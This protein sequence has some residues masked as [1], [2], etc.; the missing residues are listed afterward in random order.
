MLSKNQIKFIRSLQQKKQRML[1]KQFVIEGSRMVLELIDSHRSFLTYVVVTS[2]FIEKHSLSQHVP[3]V[4]T[5]EETFS[6]LTT[7]IQ[8][9]GILAVFRQ[10]ELTYKASN[11][12]LFLD[13]IQDPG[14]MGTIIRLADWF[15]I[16]QIV[17]SPD[18]VD[19]F[20][21]K[22]VQSSMGSIFRVPM[23]YAQLEELL[24]STK[25][26]VYGAMLDGDSIYEQQLSATGIIVMGNEGN[27]IRPTVEHY[28]SNKILI[29]R[30]GG[31]ES[32]N[33]STATGILLS[34]F[35]RNG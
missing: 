4:V 34:E 21:P 28:L 14:N 27:G 6:K 2:S 20:N 29:P 24:A 5:D 22:V 25:L 26:P 10:P 35:R 33:V 12:M 15:G 18:C 23:V 31:G 9:Q 30:F 17:C 19:V 8:P 13:N 32:L 1:H 3:V 7:S 11:F 16:E